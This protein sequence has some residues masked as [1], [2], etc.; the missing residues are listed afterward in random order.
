MA[1]AQE[2]CKADVLVWLNR[3]GVTSISQRFRSLL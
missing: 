2:G 3:V 1:V